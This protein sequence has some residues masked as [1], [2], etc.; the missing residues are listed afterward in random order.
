MFGGDQKDYLDFANDKN[1]GEASPTLG[2]IYN[3]YLGVDQTINQAGKC[4]LCFEKVATVTVQI[5]RRLSAAR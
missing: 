1:E 2:A 3:K 5:C 4:L